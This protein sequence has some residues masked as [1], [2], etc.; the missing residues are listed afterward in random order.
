MGPPKEI[1]PSLRN[2]RSTSSGEWLDMRSDAPM[3]PP[4]SLQ[5]PVADILLLQEIT[6]PRATQQR[7]RRQQPGL[8]AR[9]GGDGH[10][11]RRL[12]HRPSGAR[13]QNMAVAYTV[14]QEVATRV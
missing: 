5:Q 3:S 12:R 9:A 6:R 11:A 13:I 1:K 14:L 10:R 4:G 2:T 8:R 7:Q